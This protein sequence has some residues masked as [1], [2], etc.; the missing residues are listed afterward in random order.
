MMGSLLTFAQLQADLARAL[1]LD[2]KRLRVA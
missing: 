1:P 2:A